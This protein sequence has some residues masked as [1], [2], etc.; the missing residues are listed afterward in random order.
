LFLAIPKPPSDNAGPFKMQQ[1]LHNL[2]RV[3]YAGA[4]TLV[5][6]YI[7]PIISI[8]TACSRQYR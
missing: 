6:R 8:L 2:A 5:W 4:I 1:L 3:D 7:S